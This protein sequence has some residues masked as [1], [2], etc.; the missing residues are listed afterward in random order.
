MHSTG[1]P[2]INAD[3]G[4]GYGAFAYGDDEGV[5]PHIHIAN[6][7]CGFH[8]GDPQTI[9]RCVRMAKRHGLK[10][11]AHPSLPD[12]EG[13]GRRDL[14]LGRDALRDCV[15][16]QVGAL[17]GF[18]AAEG[19]SLSYLKP[20]GMMYMQ[21]ARD[22]ALAEALC[23]TAETFGVGVFGI[24]GTHT[25][26]VANR[27]RLPFLGEFFVDLAYQDDGRL[28]VTK[29]KAVDPDWVALRLK[30]AV[31]DGVV[32]TIGGVM[33]PIAFR[34]ICVHN[35]MP[36]AREIARAARAALDDIKA[37]TAQT[38]SDSGAL[39]QGIDQQGESG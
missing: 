23:D 35:D 13:F 19:L 37:E 2:E 20:H 39:P 30:R 1:V 26:N 21:A 33:R 14:R 32:E 15:L 3:M 17:N 18:L 31:R 9:S 16:Y 28:I 7:A 5:A 12:Q 27:R 25:E 8:G 4:E 29:E 38:I 10:I 34:T 6:I 36:N 22:E 11:A 24:S